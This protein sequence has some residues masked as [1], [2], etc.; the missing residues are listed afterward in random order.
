MR[1]H[2]ARPSPGS[3][4]GSPQAARGGH[5]VATIRSE[6]R[7]FNRYASRDF[8]TEIFSFLTEARLVRVN[9]ATQQVEPWL[10]ES[11]TCTRDG[12]GCTMKLRRGLTFSDGVP[13]TS[14]DVVF[15]FQA[16][17]DGPTGSPLAESV[18]V[19]GKQ[20]A[21][22]APDAS[23]VVIRFP[24]SFGPGVRI[25]DN[26]PI[27]PRHKLES[28]LRAGSLR[29]AWGTDT[30]PEELAGL[31]PFV[32]REYVSGQRLVFAR[33]PRYWRKDAAGTALPYL[34][35]LTL[36]VVPD[37]NA[38]LLRLESGQSDMTQSEV[39]PDDYAMLKRA[40]AAGK[41]RLFD[42]GLAFDSDCFWFNLQPSRASDP[43]HAWLQSLQFRRAV[44]L[45]VDR[46]G[47]ADAVFLGAADPIWGPVSPANAT[48]YP[49]ASS[50]A[51]PSPPYDPAGARAL[52]G[53]AGLR[54]RNND[55]LLEDAQGAPVRFALLTQRGQTAL[56]RGAAVIRDDLR[57]IGITVDVVA[58]EV[59]ALVERMM[60]GDYDAIYFRFVMTDTDPALNLDFWLSS[61][62]A[63]VWN[64]A[65][66]TPA[67]AWERELDGLML[68]QAAET[69]LAGRQ[70][71]FWQAQKLLADHLPVIYFA[72]PRVFVATS[73]RV[74]GAIPA[75]VRPPLLWAPDTLAIKQ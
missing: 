55:G 5:L 9:R 18:A 22:S 74:T 42:A 12:L 11:W 64:M 72:V 52:L 8:A 51:V 70:R 58:L 14:A 3:A 67:T 28:A 63:H 6:P 57:K 20:I 45:A 10:A 56:E 54:D 15:S 31:G 50:R 29:K 47:F 27:L 71:L 13:F 7:S 26:L 44:S 21:V 59:G 40:E 35:G 32:L 23:T 17:Y 48:W 37:Q 66:K 60:K 49:P 46:K 41:L 75:P 34:D 62:S 68:K 61:G 33:N 36:E 39:R 43:R 2:P 19:G 38:E 4:S 65:Q 16:I 53:E 69:S 73:S 1:A 25:L 30:R 24:S